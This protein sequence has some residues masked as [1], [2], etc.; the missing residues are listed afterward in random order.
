[1][2]RCIVHLFVVPI[3]YVGQQKRSSTFI[4]SSW[5]I[6]LATRKDASRLPFTMREISLTL[7]PVRLAISA[8]VSRA[9][10][11]ALRSDSVGFTIRDDYRL[12]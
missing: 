4:W 11:I 12:P 3:T 2:R 6:A 10:F 8:C 1:M 7:R 9:S 5:A